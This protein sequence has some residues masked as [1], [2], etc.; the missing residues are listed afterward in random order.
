[1]TD[2]AHALRKEGVIDERENCIDATCAFAKSSGE[3]GPA[4]RRKGVRSNRK[5]RK[6]GQSSATSL[7]MT[8]D[9]RVILRLD[10]MEAPA[11]HFLQGR[12][13]LPCRDAETGNT[14]A[15][16]P[17]FYNTVKSNRTT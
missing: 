5:K 1:M 14:L 2:L 3:I 12:L 4:Q 9:G 8:L 7:R 13:S 15:A 10:A 17:H 11:P 16:T 6:T